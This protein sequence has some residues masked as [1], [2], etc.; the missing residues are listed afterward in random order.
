MLLTTVGDIINHAP[1]KTADVLL[2][3]VTGIVV[4][5]GIGQSSASQSLAQA[6]SLYAIVTCAD[7]RAVRVDVGGALSMSSTTSKNI[8]SESSSDRSSSVSVKDLFFFHTASVWGV[9]TERKIGA[10][11]VATVGEDKMLCVWDTDGFYLTC[12]YSWHCT[13]LYCTVSP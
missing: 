13:V 9:A 1:V 4:I 11:L 3:A 5:Q 2:A 12:R 7:G 8:R 10:T 6:Q